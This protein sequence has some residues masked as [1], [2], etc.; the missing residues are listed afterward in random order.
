MGSDH[1]VWLLALWLQ[2]A[3]PS[4]SLSLCSIAAFHSV[5]PLTVLPA[6]P[7]LVLLRDFAGHGELHV[8]VQVLAKGCAAPP[9]C[10]SRDNVGLPRGVPAELLGAPQTSAAPVVPSV[11]GSFPCA[12]YPLAALKI[13]LNSL[14]LASPVCLLFMLK[15]SWK[16]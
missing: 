12:L 14:L 8:M 13:Y 4:H 15:V 1:P 6:A 11:S 16:I 2:P 7:L 5:R 10:K 9:N 3:A